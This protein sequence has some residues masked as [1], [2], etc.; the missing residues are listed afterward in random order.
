MAKSPQDVSGH[1]GDIGF[2]AAAPVP[3]GAP[4]SGS[5]QGF[6]EYADDTSDPT[7]PQSQDG[8]RSHAWGED[9]KQI[10]TNRVE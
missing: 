10:G 9:T 4:G 7:S 5:K 6:S 1:S 2:G 3:T 8:Y